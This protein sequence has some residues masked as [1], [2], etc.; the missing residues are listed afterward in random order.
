MNLEFIES[1]LNLN[2]LFVINHSGGKDSQAMLIELSQLIPKDRMIVV[3]ASLGEI[4]WPGALDL[5]KKQAL[6]LELPFLV[7]Q[8]KKTFFDMVLNRYRTR[9][10]VPSWP[11]ATTRQCTSDLKRDP[12][13]KVVRL[14]A[15][16]NNFTVIVNCMGIRAEE[17]TSRSKK[18]PISL[19]VAPSN[20][21]LTWH[22]W[23]P[24]HHKTTEDVFAIIKNANQVPHKAY[25]LGNQRLSCIF[26]I[27][28]S[29]SDLRNGAA[30]FPELFQRYSE[31]ESTT[32]YTMHMSRDSLIKLVQ[33]K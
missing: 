4:E 16:E 17:S 31:I 29:K 32:G 1:M 9:P 12:I 30:L 22:E 18:K 24:I 15:K 11:S 21:R 28:G 26:C 5:A 33:E 7:A 20:S 27:M 19:N 3:H 2:S 14:Y 13:R 25:S 23:L 6:D 8:S 10:D